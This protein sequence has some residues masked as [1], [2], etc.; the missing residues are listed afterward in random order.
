[1]TA[2]IAIRKLKVDKSSKRTVVV[3]FWAPERVA[4][5]EWRCPYEV[6]GGGL[7]GLKYSYGVDS[8]Q[9]LGLVF[10]AVRNDLEALKEA[11]WFDIPLQGCFPS[12]VPFVGDIEVTR[13]IEKMIDQELRAN[14]K[15]LK[16]K[17]ERSQ[18]KSG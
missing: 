17:Y 8:M 3:Q 15:S 16:L 2:P 5:D 12:F 14:L 13:R 6:R 10:Q 1:M 11:T 18:K 7:R 9:A 4:S